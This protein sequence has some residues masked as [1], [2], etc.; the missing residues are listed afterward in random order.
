MTKQTISRQHGAVLYTRVSGNEQEK[1]GTSPETQK[2]ACRKKALEM[3][4]PIIAEYHDGGVSGGFLLARKEFQSALA[5]IQAGRAGT[6]I[7]PNLSRYSRDV[8]HQQAVK[9]AVRAAGGQLVFC[10]MEFADTPEGDLNFT[11]QGGFAEYERQVIRA[12]CMKGKR[13]RAE[14]G[15]QMSPSRSPYGYRIVLKADVLKGD[16]PAEMLGRYTVEE[17][18]AEIV[19]EL[20]HRYASGECG[21]PALAKDFNRRGVPLP[22]GG[23]L[24]R[25]SSLRCL[26]HNPVYKGEPAFGRFA[27]RRDESRLLETN[28]ITG[29]PRKDTR[30]SL[31]APEGY[32]VPLSAPPLVTEAVWEAAQERMKTNSGSHSGNPRRARMLS[33]RVFCPCGHKATHRSN[34]E[35]GA[36]YGTPT[37]YQCSVA[38]NAQSWTGEGAEACSL[39]LFRVSA[40]EAATVRAFLSAASAP[41]SLADAWRASAERKRAASQQGREEPLPGNLRQE[42]AALDKALSALAADDLLA[43]QAQMAGMKSGASP[44]AYAAVFAELAGRRKDLEDRRGQVSRLLTTPYSSAEAQKPQGAAKQDVFGPEW[45]S[46]ALEE[47]ALVLSAPDVP[48]ETKRRIIGLVVEKVVCQKDG[49]DVY[50]LPG[51][52]IEGNQTHLNQTWQSEQVVEWLAQDWDQRKRDAPPST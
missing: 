11:I 46:K 23:T 33:G 37:S 31:P 36:R 16:F 41:Q 39:E 35:Q 27:C 5:D 4:L 17:A 34:G 40:A 47:A 2:D 42:K 19:R 50:F 14:E 52:A 13:K 44:D 43:V 21:T 29:L 15:R 49:A 25:C 48:G 1:H 18:Q 30:V 12:R 10:D 24:W 51:F 20:F 38:R 3:S 26:L 8:E 7:C 9:K 32:A 45:T 6:L 22:R 28:A